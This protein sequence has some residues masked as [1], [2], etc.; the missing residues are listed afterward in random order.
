[1]ATIAT[2]QKERREARLADVERQVKSGSLVIRQM[3]AEERAK[4]PPRPR[5]ARRR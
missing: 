5:P 3:T 2:Q 1:V 4:N